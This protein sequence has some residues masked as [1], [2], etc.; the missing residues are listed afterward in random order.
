MWS[1]FSS[2]VFH[3]QEWSL[4]NWTHPQLSV[5][6][7]VSVFTPNPPTQYWNFQLAPLRGVPFP[8]GWC[9]G[10]KDEPLLRLWSVCAVR[11]GSPCSLDPDWSRVQLQF[12]FAT[13]LLHIRSNK[14]GEEEVVL[15]RF[16]DWK[17]KQKCMFVPVTEIAFLCLFT[18]EAPEPWICIRK[19][20][21]LKK[22]YL[23]WSSVRDTCGLWKP[24][25]NAVIKAS[26]LCTFVVIR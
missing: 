21:F 26:C 10:W 5:R 4:L 24:L 11:G 7:M 9:H 13:L 18:A 1:L 3:M 15:W 8:V 6:H 12:S 16:C 22:S 25:S 20:L 17:G 23:W 2:W 19:R 14:V